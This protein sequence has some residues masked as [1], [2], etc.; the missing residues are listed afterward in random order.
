MLFELRGLVQNALMGISPVRRLVSRAHVTGMCGEP[1]LVAERFAAYAALV[2]VRGKDIVELGPGQTPDV[3]LSAMQA[4]ARSCVGLDTQWYSEQ[5]RVRG[6]PVS[7]RIYDGRRLPLRDESVDVV[8]SSDVLEHVRYPEALVADLARVLRPGGL[9][10]AGVDLRDHYHLDDEARWLD[11]LRYRESVWRALTWN[12][13]GYVNRLRVS[14]WERLFDRYGFRILSLDRQRSPLLA[15]LWDS[16]RIRS[17]AG[18]ISRED[19]SVYGFDL[20]AMK[21]GV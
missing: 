16:G 10:I 11:C 1:G 13:A 14:Q 2:D 17:A 20:F 7:I 3:L 12:R 4:G 9:I 5:E 8:W 18:P 21:P 6:T 15:E 19:A